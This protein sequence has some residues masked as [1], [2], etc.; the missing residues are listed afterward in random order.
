MGQLQFQIY[1]ESRTMGLSYELE[2][3]W[4][5]KKEVTMIPSVLA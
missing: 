3:G 5:T 2:K 4:K 1:F